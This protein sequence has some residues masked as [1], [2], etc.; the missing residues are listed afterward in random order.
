MCYWL[1]C[2]QAKVAVIILRCATDS[3]ANGGDV[4][5]PTV[6]CSTVLF[7]ALSVLRLNASGTTAFLPG[8]CTIHYGVSASFLA[9][10][11]VVYK[12]WGMFKS[13][14]AVCDP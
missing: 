3:C 11:I 5:G 8:K 1:Q 2:G 7:G 10:G 12:V 14:S 6:W 4:V 13:A 9:N